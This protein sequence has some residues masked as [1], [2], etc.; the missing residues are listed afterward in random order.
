MG[1]FERQVWQRTVSALPSNWTAE[2]SIPILAS[3]CHHV[4]AARIIDEKVAQI[5][6]GELGGLRDL[7]DMREKPTRALTACARALR[8]TQQ[9]RSVSETRRLPQGSPP[10]DY[11][12]A[13]A[14]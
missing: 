1:G 12:S 2:A 11:S 14:A 9:G 6:V 3:Y 10:W 4:A 5:S 13:G 8:L 7:L